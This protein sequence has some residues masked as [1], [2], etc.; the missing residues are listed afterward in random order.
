MFLNLPS[1]NLI[2]ANQIEKDVLTTGQHRNGAYSVN[3]NC[4]DDSDYLMTIL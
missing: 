4:I 2:D 3:I 1:G